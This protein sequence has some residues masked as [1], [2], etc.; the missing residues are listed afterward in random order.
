MLE[1][2]K[3]TETFKSLESLFT[4]ECVPTVTNTAD[5]LADWYKYG[6]LTT[7]FMC[8]KKLILHFLFR[9]AQAV[10]L[11]AEILAKDVSAID[12]LW[13]DT[14]KN[15]ERFQF[16]YSTKLH[17]LVEAIKRRQSFP[18]GEILS[19]EPRMTAGA[20]DCKYNKNFSQG[21]VLLLFATIFCNFTLI[22]QSNYN[23]LD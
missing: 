5:L 4:A 20:A 7:F 9:M 2:I 22:L 1:R 23:F 21:L 14:L 12:A 19:V 10:V 13:V 16:S 8:E 3:M 11:Q 17:E 6:I 18:T 15:Q